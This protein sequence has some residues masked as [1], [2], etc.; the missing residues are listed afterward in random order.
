M[1]DDDDDIQ[2]CNR[3]PPVPRTPGDILKTGVDFEEDEEDGPWRV[4]WKRPT[5][6][7]GNDLPDTS[8][9][10]TFLTNN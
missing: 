10:K 8:N 1:L 4:G 7:S 9:V 5:T 3:D 6:S 2:Y